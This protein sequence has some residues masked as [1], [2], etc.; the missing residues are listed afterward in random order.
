MP[1]QGIETTEEL[2]NTP[3]VRAARYVRMSTDHQQY[4]TE[5]HA[6]VIAEYART[7]W[8]NATQPKRILLLELVA[9][10]VRRPQNAGIRPSSRT[11]R[12]PLQ[13]R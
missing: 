8:N 3:P 6:E 10:W 4:S 7:H 9:K 1:P 5:N 2:R 13:G 12:P 11:F